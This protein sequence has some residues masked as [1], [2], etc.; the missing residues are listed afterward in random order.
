[1]MGDCFSGAR[2]LAMLFHAKR[3]FAATG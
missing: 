1:M 2:T 3:G